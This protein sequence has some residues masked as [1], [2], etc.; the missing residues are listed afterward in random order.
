MQENIITTASQAEPQ[1]EQSIDVKAIFYLFL[2]H[3]YWFLIS[4]VLAL[5]LATF[6]L[7]KT[8]PVYTRTAKVLVKEDEKG[9]SAFNVSDFSNLGMF[10]NGVNINNELITINS[11]DVIREAVRRLHL[12]MN[13][14][15]D[16]RFHPILLYDRTLPVNVSL[17]G[18]FDNVGPHST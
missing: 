6:Y 3:W 9:K 4:A 1:N 15:I 17:L 2:S 7:K 18:G 16:G 8:V 11:I 12:D 14:T 10:T 5:G 13:Y